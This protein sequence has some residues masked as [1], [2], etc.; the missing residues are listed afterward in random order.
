MR[1]VGRIAEEERGW[2]SDWPGSIETLDF[3]PQ[4]EALRQIEE[5]DYL[6]LTMTD[7]ISIPGKL[8]EYLA[9]GKPIIAFA[10][11]GGEVWSFFRGD[12]GGVV[13]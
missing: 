6:L 1:F 7:A 12:A 13:P 10:A 8:H 9:A 4:A 11:P 2:L 3:L 5:T